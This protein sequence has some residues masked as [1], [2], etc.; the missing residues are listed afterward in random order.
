MIT[1]AGAMSRRPHPRASSRSGG[2][3]VNRPGV[4]PG[5]V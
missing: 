4:R 2:V 3:R 5:R 1:A